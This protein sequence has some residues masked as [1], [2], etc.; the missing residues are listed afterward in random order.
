MSFNSKP[1]Y[2]QEDIEEIGKKISALSQLELCKLNRFA[3][4][5]HEFFRNDLILLNGDNLGSHFMKTLH[6]KGGFTPEISK[7]LGWINK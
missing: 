4:V 5:G 7:Q 2:T 3:P 1:Q 6:A